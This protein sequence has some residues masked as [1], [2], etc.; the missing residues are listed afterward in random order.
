MPTTPPHQPLPARPSQCPP[1]ATRTSG[2]CLLVFFYACFISLLLAH[3]PFPRLPVVCISLAP[4][5]SILPP[6]LPCLQV[7]PLPLQSPTLP[8]LVFSLPLT[9]HR[10]W[11]NGQHCR[12]S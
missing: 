9:L 1:S 2:T 8:A 7:R 3:A 10:I 11:C 6:A 4:S 12:L 5:T